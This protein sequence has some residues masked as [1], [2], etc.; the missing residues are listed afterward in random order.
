[1]KHPEF[2]GL[3][4]ANVRAAAEASLARLGVETIDLYYA[5][6]DDPEVPLADVVE[7]FAALVTDGLVR[8]V[9]LSNFSA[10]RIEEWARLA[11]DGPAAPVALQ[12]HYNLVH[13]EEVESSLVPVAERHG[14]SLVPYFG[15]E[16]GF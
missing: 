1:A 12:P 8:H 5:H 3:A 9:A 2:P 11:A 6:H 15:L 10:E 7:A 4:P 13:R 14:M 16:R